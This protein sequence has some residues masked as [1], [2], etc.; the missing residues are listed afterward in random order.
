MKKKLLLLGLVV[1]SLIFLVTVS[2]QQITRADRVIAY[3]EFRRGVQAWYR[4]AFNDSILVFEKALSHLPGEPLILEWLG[5]A[6]YRSGVEGA[7]LQ[8][9]QFAADAGHGGILLKNKIETV[10]YRR[11]YSRSDPASERYVESAQISGTRDGQVLFRQPVSAA[12]VADGSFWVVAYGSN[13]L[14]HFDVNG[15]ILGRSRGPLSGFD[16]P[17]DV[18]ALSDGR[19]LVSEMGADRISLIAP[20]GSYDASFGKKGR[21]LGELVGPQY[22]AVD[23]TGNIYVTDFGNARVMVFDPEG[24]A[25]FSFGQ[26]SALF[27]GFSAPAGLVVLDSRVLVSDMVSGAL[28][29]FDTAGNYLDTVLPEGSIT[30]CQSLRTWKEGI[31]VALPNRVLSV[32]TRTFARSEIARLGN[33]P[34]RIT[35]VIPDVNG[36]L[37]MTDYKGGFVQVASRS[38][39]LV[40]GLFVH[41]DRVNA[42]KF[43]SVTLELRVEDRNR[44]PVVGLKDANFLITEGQRPVITPR[45]LGAGFM[46]D[47]LDVTVILDRSPASAARLQDIRAAL[48]DISRAMKGKGTIRVVSAGS[49]PVLEGSSPSSAPIWSSFTP[50]TQVARDWKFD[51][52]LRLAVNDLINAS[53]RRAVI[54]LSCGE[55]GDLS[56]NR[57]ALNDLASYLGNN[58]VLFTTIYLTQGQAVSEFEYLCAATS[59]RSWY[60]YRSEGL[61]ETIQSLLT[62]PNGSYQLSYVSSLPTDFGKAYLPVEVEVYL[63]NRSGRDETGYFSPLE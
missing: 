36:N 47:A 29:A 56:F 7:A 30:G 54:F 16:R 41:V 39:D 14:V 53:A 19:L 26:K 37:I 63:M 49:L 25:L 27:P 34:S 5:K 35:A 1:L 8:Q 28:Y 33:A 42:D 21:G 22:L 23:S 60:L 24:K 52:A 38:A 20:N 10:R 55:V 15:Q 2:A 9:W 4:G 44:R 13:E 61:A 57:Y 11:S 12:A 48:A 17:F 32:D 43:P 31:L 45:L 51:V 18:L 58:G 50:R 62:S 3:E 46:Q 6:Y 59:M 40:G